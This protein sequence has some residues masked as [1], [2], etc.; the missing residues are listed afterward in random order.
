MQRQSSTSL[1]LIT[2]IFCPFSLLKSSR[3]F[4][5]SVTPVLLVTLSSCLVKWFLNLTISSY[6]YLNFELH[7][8]LP[9]HFIILHPYFIWILWLIE[10]LIS[11]YFPESQDNANRWRATVFIVRKNIIFIFLITTCQVTSIKFHTDK[12]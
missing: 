12:K 8:A 3:S 9:I 11:I 1:F 6:F 10:K 5:G 4:S 2:N 7:F